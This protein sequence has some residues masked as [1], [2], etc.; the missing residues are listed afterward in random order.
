MKYTLLDEIGG[1]FLDQVVE[2]VRKGRKFVF[3]LDNIDWD[4][5]VNDMR[6]DNQTD[7]HHSSEVYQ[8]T[9]E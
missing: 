5:K 9:G 2:L 1:H 7:G 3:V 6:S 8:G 4:V